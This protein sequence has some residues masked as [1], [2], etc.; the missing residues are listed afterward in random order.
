MAAILKFSAIK[1][2]KEIAIF[3]IAIFISL[4]IS[5]CALF[6]LKIEYHIYP[7]KIEFGY[8]DPVQFNTLYQADKDLFLGGK[9]LRT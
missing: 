3:C 8:P 1:Y 5:E 2:K 9:K 4:G 7:Q 6:F